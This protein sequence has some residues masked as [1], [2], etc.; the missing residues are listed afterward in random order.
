RLNGE[1]WFT[2]RG[3]PWTRKRVLQVLRNPV[4]A[5]D[6]VYGR[7]ERR[8]VAAVDGDPLQRRRQTVLARNPEFVIVC[9]GAHP[10][11]V[12]QADFQRVQSLLASRGTPARRSPIRP[13]AGGVLACVCGSH[14]SVKYN[15]AG[16]AYYA[17]NARINRGPRA[18]KLPFIRAQA[19]EQA[20]LGRI[21]QDVEGALQRLSGAGVRWSVPPAPE[22]ASLSPAEID[23][24]IQ[25]ELEHLHALH[26]RRWAGRL[27][28]ESF[29][30]LAERV[31]RRL[32][33]LRRVRGVSA[34]AV[35]GDDSTVDPATLIPA[36]RSA[37]QDPETGGPRWR[38]ALLRALVREIRILQWDASAVQ[39]QVVYRFRLPASSG[40]AGSP[41][42]A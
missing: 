28:E 16:T 7:R 32:A 40:K 18:C 1:G 35:R 22:Q 6:V 10:A 23:A 30:R 29:E 13:F 42:G 27:D 37:L 21:R 8:V 39:L 15:H 41:G 26:E 24:R 31:T 11:L 25:Q 33:A 5:G 20:V 3:R 9:R 12:S 38:A 34:S 14:I 36:L 2:R 17:C 19:L 4:Y